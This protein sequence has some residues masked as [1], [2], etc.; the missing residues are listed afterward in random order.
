MR[1]HCHRTMIIQIID[2][3][4]KDEQMGTFENTKQRKGQDN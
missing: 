1:K 2:E 4:Y 3:K